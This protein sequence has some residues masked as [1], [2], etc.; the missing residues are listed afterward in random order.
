MK[1]FYKVVILFLVVVMTLSGCSATS[2]RSMSDPPSFNKGLD[3]LKAKNF[4]QASFYFSELARKGDPAAMNNLGIA[5]MMVNRKEEAIYW[6]KK[7]TIYGDRNAIKSLNELGEKVPFADLVG[8]HP[9]VVA[10]QENSRLMQDIFITT[11]VGV[12]LGVSLHYSQKSG[13]YVTNYNPWM[14]NSTVQ[15]GCSNHYGCGIGKKCV[16]APFESIGV[17]MKVV[18]EY[19]LPTY[20]IPK[21]S[22]VGVNVDIDG[23]CRVDLDCPTGFKCDTK[24]KVCVKR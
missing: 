2:M 8:K 5:L 9:S 15:N 14:H 7:A 16:K 18:D 23:D 17:C 4:D 22:G 1:I 19:G 12:A 6:F 20:D 11:L 21:T 24:Y 13:S 10:V 3:A